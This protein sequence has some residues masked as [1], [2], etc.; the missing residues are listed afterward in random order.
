[1]E[2]FTNPILPF[3]FLRATML[4]NIVP[5]ARFYKLT[6]FDFLIT[7][8]MSNFPVFLVSGSRIILINQGILICFFYLIS[9]FVISILLTIK[10]FIK[11]KYF[12][13]KKYINL[14]LAKVRIFA[15]AHVSNVYREFKKSFPILGN[16]PLY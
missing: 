5:T 9:K 10:I 11:H 1:M 12:S 8:A 13:F 16:M 3:R 6:I 2:R 7:I 15:E 4:K 14:V